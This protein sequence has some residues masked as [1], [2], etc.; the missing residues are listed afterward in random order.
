[1]SDFIDLA[2]NRYGHLTAIRRD[3]KNEKGQTLWILKCDC[4]KEVSLPMTNFKYGK[5][6][7]C[8]CM[9]APDLTG[10]KFN[11]L[12]VIKKDGTY[13]GRG[14]NTRWLCLCDCGNYTHAP[15]AALRGG[16]QIS[17]GCYASERMTK[18]NMK[19]GG[20]GTR[21]YEIWRQMHR[22]CYGKETKAYPYYGGRGI[23]IC[24][25]W[26]EFE[27][28]KKWAIENGYAD[29]LTIDRIDVNGNYEQSN[30]RWVTAKEQANNRRSNHKVEYNG[31]THTVSEWADKYGVSQVK[32]WA[33][34]DKRNWQ[35]K[36]ALES[37][38][39]DMSGR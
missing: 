36:P 25:E 20:F 17:C 35:L 1:M 7:S 10:M 39:V 21:L 11:R 19:H 22:R 32:L 27:P 14:R 23:T 2:G 30:C 8:G 4:G 29:D 6:K 13:N 28:F 16:K 37:L 26:K 12:T 33:R 15:T 31:E 38:G 9:R 24:D 3:G 34:L 5:Q 18:M